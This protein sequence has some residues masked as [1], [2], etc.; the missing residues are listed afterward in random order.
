MQVNIFNNLN[1]LLNYSNNI[2]PFAIK[3]CESKMTQILQIDKN[4]L[5]PGLTEI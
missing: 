3:C 2:L 5:K 1:R 4:I